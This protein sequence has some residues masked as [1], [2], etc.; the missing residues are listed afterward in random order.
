MPFASLQ[1][2]DYL[3]MNWCSCNLV[4]V[5]LQL[6]TISL[7]LVSRPP[8]VLCRQYFIYNN[9]FTSFLFVHTT[10]MSDII[11]STRWDLE[12]TSPHSDAKSI[13]RSAKLLELSAHSEVPTTERKEATSTSAWETILNAN[14]TNERNHTCRIVEEPKVGPGPAPEDENYSTANALPEV[15]ANEVKSSVTSALEAII[16]MEE[17]AVEQLLHAAPHCAQ[18][19]IR[20]MVPNAVE[21]VIFE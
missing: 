11:R 20:P 2:S 21:H 18:R 3:R 1:I 15:I 13:Q 12:L 7:Q 9:P 19:G 4:P 8:T 10:R 6:L 5:I 17:G 16:Y 14:N